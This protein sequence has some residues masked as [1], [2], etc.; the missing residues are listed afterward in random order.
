[1]FRFALLTD[2]CHQ[3]LYDTLLAARADSSTRQHSSTNLSRRRHGHLYGIQLW[4][5]IWIVR[6][7][8]WEVEWYQDGTHARG[9]VRQTTERE[10]TCSTKIR[11]IS[12]YWLLISSFSSL[13]HLFLSSVCYPIGAFI[14][15][16]AAVA[17]SYLPNYTAQSSAA[18]NPV[19]D[20]DLDEEQY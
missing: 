19:N 13:F 7:R 14:G 11:L 20:D 5:H 17:N 2:R 12:I 3:L 4:I 6:C 1:M 16:I 8:G 10:E 15:A 9:E 18:Y